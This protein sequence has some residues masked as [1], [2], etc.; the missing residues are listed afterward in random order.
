MGSYYS[1][2]E[3]IAFG[4]NSVGENVRV[5][6]KVSLY[7][8]F[9]TLGSNLRIDDNVVLIGNIS[10]GSYTHVAPNCLLNSGPSTITIEDFVSISSNCSIFGSSDDYTGDS[11]CNPCCPK[12]FVVSN[13]DPVL[14]SRG[15]ALG[16]NTV[17]LPGSLIPKYTTIGALSLVQ[18]GM[19]LSLGTAYISRAM[20]LTPIHK[21]DITSLETKVKKILIAEKTNI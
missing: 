15:S 17:V 3:L 2:E 16:A 8:I 10:I 4:F 12:E 9:G 13:N 20:M 14:I 21:R 19:N 1:K 5:T 11:L 18:K 6:R 7:K